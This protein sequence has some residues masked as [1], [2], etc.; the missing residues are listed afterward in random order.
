VRTP[1]AAQ[2]FGR[3]VTIADVDATF[4]RWL[5]LGYDLDALHVVLATAA[6]ERLTGDPLWT[7]LISGS[8]NA[9]TETVQSLV[10]AGA[11]VVSTIA[12]EGALLSG[13]AKREKS[14]DA[15]GGLLH[16]I[17]SR[18]LLVVKD[19]TSIL[20]MN[21]DARAAV[22][23]AIRE[24]HDGHWARNVGTDGGRTLT[25][26]GRIGIVGACTTAW[27]RAHDVVASMGD[28]F[29]VVPTGDRE[30]GRRRTHAGRTL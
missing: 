6:A 9:K 10:G 25:W 20:S 19:V 17:G 15:T 22:L 13:T 16:Q 26:R 18:G 3:R 11:I 21:R 5:G 30:H 29:V 12:S 28:R 24:I 2:V 4:R 7:L 8:G 23:A 14:A 27:D 1:A